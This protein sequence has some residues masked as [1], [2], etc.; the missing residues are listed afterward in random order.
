MSASRRCRRC[1]GRRPS[2]ACCPA[3]HRLP[4]L[5]QLGLGDETCRQLLDATARTQGL[6]LITGPTGS[7]K[8]NTLYAALAE[9]VGRGRNVL[10]LEDPVEIELP[11]ITQVQVDDRIGMTF[12]RGLRAA[13]RQDPDVI[14]VG[15]IRDQETAELAVRASL[16]GHLVLS[17]LHTTDAAAAV[18]RLSDMGVA[19]YLVASSL[20]LVASQRLVRVPCPECSR[21]DV[22]PS[23]EHLRRRHRRR[24]GVGGIGGVPQLP[25]HG[26]HRP[27]S[28]H[29]G[30]A[31]HRRAA[32]RAAPRCERGRAC[33][34]WHAPRGFA[35]CS[36]SAWRRL[37]PARRL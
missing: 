3:A 19:T 16:T 7:G 13:L 37:D 4:T 20:L 34:R 26:I 32:L 18:T 12:A 29:R 10:T 28:R 35:R 23:L 9:G 24:G 30:A 5:A 21:P 31:D 1:T 27:D 17:T 33:G 36:T 8:T 22:E 2:S 15:E 25:A 11:G 6:I 14:L